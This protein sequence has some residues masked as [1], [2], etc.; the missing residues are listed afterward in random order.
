MTGIIQVPFETLKIDITDEQ[1]QNIKVK[2]SR[3]DFYKNLENLGYQLADNF[4]DIQE[5][6]LTETGTTW[7]SI[8]L[9]RQFCLHYI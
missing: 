1:A 9:S 7:N 8:L 3:D 4:K 6:S 2:I 5:L